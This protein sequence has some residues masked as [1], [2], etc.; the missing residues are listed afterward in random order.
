MPFWQ[1]EEAA[2]GGRWRDAL[3]KRNLMRAGQRFTELAT[4]YAEAIFLSSMV[5]DCTAKHIT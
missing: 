5:W 3:G 2:T 1:D 4:F